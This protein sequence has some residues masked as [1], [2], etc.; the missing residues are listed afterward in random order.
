MNSQN[1]S[2]K[3]GASRQNGKI[4]QYFQIAVDFSFIWRVLYSNDFQISNHWRRER[5]KTTRI[6]SGWNGIDE[7]V[8][9]SIGSASAWATETNSTRRKMECRG[10]EIVISSCESTWKLVLLWCDDVNEPV[11]KVY[12][13]FQKYCNHFG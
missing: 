6:K 12:C 11:H 4:H 9:T 5:K 1:K 10:K 8:T 2:K 7:T 13:V 3:D